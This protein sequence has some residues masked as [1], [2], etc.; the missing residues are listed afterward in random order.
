[1]VSWREREWPFPPSASIGPEG[2]RGPRAAPRATAG[3]DGPRPHVW[4]GGQGG[5]WGSGRRCG[6]QESPPGRREVGGRHPPSEPRAPVEP[7]G[8]G[9]VQ[10]GRAAAGRRAPWWGGGW[11]RRRGEAGW[12][13][14]APRRRTGGRGLRRASRSHPTCARTRRGH[15]VTESVHFAGTDRHELTSWKSFPS[16]F[17]FFTEASEAKTSS[18]KPALTRRSHRIKHEE[19]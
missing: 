15:L 3:K 19:L 1:M 5:C 16:I 9:G 4:L 18:L 14:R 12:R 6:V 2:L 8:T 7:S 11:A 10:R 17:K 13:A